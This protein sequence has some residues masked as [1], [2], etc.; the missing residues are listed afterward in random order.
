MYDSRGQVYYRTPETLLAS[1]AMHGDQAM[2]YTRE[3]L[4]HYLP[5]G[6]GIS[7]TIRSRAHLGAWSSQE[8]FK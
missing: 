8:S 2:P 3:Q 4:Q 1:Y 6:L 7:Q 5:G